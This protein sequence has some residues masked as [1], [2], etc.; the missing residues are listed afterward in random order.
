MHFQAASWGSYAA[1]R[2]AAVGDPLERIERL[3]S[4]N[5]GGDIQREHVLHVPRHQEAVLRH[6]REP[7]GAR[8]GRG[9][10][11][12]GPREGLD[13]APGYPFCGPRRFHWRQACGHHGQSHGVPHQWHACPSPQRSWGSLALMETTD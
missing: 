13:E 3:A 12:Q 6:G 2:S 1:P 11:R 10:Q 7:D 5:A 4:E 9:P 8:V